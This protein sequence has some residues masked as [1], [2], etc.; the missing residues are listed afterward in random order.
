MVLAGYKKQE[1]ITQIGEFSR[2]GE[3]VDVFPISSD[4]PF[5]IDF[6]DTEIESIKIFDITS[7]KAT[8]EIDKLEINPCCDVFLENVDTAN[9]IKSLQKL[10]LGATEDVDT[11]TIFN[12]Q[13]DEIINKIDTKNYGF[14]LNL[15]SPY[16]ESQ[17]ASIFDY[18]ELMKDKFLVVVDECKGVYDTLSNFEKESGSFFSIEYLSHN[19]L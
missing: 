18:L 12:S 19:L 14:S 17:R 3:V 16:I 4:Y 11:K 7:Q 2:R 15:I 1:I 13:I 5:R 8:K 10:K 6:F 9:I